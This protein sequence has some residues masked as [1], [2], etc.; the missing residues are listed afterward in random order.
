M[1]LT[2]NNNIKIQAKKYHNMVIYPSSSRGWA[3][4]SQVVRLTCLRWLLVIPTSS[5][6][7]HINQ[8]K[9]W[10]IHIQIVN[11]LRVIK[12]IVLIQ[13]DWERILVVLRRLL[14][15]L[16]LLELLHLLLQARKQSYRSK[17]WYFKSKQIH[18]I[19][20]CKILH[21]I[22]KTTTI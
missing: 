4:E 21:R 15:T 19:R 1:Y 6:I 17:L 8:D 7:P 12:L 18:F 20:R 9:N 2:C 10:L 11:L 5:I 13:I 22:C 16:L 3:V 14:K